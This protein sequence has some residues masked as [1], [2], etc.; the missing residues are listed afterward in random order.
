V[1]F[2]MDGQGHF[3]FLELKAR[4][5]VEHLVTEMITHI[6]LVREQIELAAGK[7]LDK[8]QEEVEMKGWALSCRIN[9]E[10][11][12]NHFLPS[13]G[14]LRRFR[15]P[16]G[17]NVRID[18]YAY[19]GCDVPLRY[20]PMLAKLVVW[21]QDRQDCIGRMRRALQDFHIS[22]VRTNLPLHQRIMQ[23]A[24]FVRGQ[25]DTEFL[26]RRLLRAEAPSQDLRDLAVAGAVAYLARYQAQRPVMPAR[27]QSG[28]HRSR[29]DVG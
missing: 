29:R 2:L 11:P 5:Q 8:R 1:E 27:L 14:Q 16:G 3:Y 13:P 28:W 21:G 22:G 9:A 23:E 26:N 18:T 20:D 17:P 4:I 19:S 25:Y 12:W 10:D 15:L 6:D 24:D 7:R